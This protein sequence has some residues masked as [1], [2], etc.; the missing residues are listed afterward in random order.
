M[1]PETTN[2]II[3]WQ[4]WEKKYK[5]L[6]QDMIDYV[7]DAQ[8]LAGESEDSVKNV[9]TVVDNN[10]NSVY[11]DILPGYRVFNRMGY[12]V[13]SEKW[14]DVDLVVSNDKSYY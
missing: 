2:G 4:Q 5:P 11:L 6:N 3:S 14:E 12:F 1:P 10:P 13:T 7:E 8:D 9:W